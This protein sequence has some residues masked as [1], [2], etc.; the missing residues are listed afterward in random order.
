M[1]KRKGLV[2]IA[3]ALV[4]ALVV[5]VVATGCGKKSTSSSSP[6]PSASS[7]AAWALPAQMNGQLSGTP[8]ENLTKILGH[9]PTG[10][11]AKI[12]QRGYLI[13]ANDPNYA[14]QSSI[15]PKTKELVGFDVDSAKAA[16]Q[17]LGLKIKWKHPNWE[18]IPANLQSGAFDVSI[19]SMTDTKLR[20]KTVS[21]TQPYYYTPAQVFV[22]KGGPQ[23]SSPQDLNGHTV[24]VGAATTYWSY[25]KKF[26][27]AKVMTYNTDLEAVPPLLNGQIEFFMTAAPTGLGLINAG[28]AIE[29]SGK[30]V[31]YEALCFATKLNETDL[32]AVFN[33]AIGKMHEVPAGSTDSL[34][35]MMSKHWYNGVDLTVT[36]GIKPLVF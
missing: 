2:L 6:S 20:E 22:K 28:K 8:T 33:Y 5:M 29:F 12:A 15:D 3:A 34:L 13:V 16:A 25:L 14:P 19:G 31:Y 32:V 23:I 27:T 4:L 9:A 24:G 21:F 35:T 26:T 10:L 36:Q 18:D 1:S 11:A 30:P 17:I 7:S